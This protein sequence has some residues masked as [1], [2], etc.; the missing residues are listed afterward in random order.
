MP[1]SILRVSIRTLNL[2]YG[3]HVQANGELAFFVLFFSRQ[4]MAV[5]VF[6]GS[7]Y[8]SYPSKKKK[9]KSRAFRLLVDA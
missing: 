5:F 3:P 6:F 2:T 1:R 8:G 7:L 4:L 9:K